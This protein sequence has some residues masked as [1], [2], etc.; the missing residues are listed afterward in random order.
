VQLRNVAVIASVLAAVGISACGSSGKS[1]SVASAPP[2]TTT[3]PPQTTTHPLASTPS[4]SPTTVFE[5]SF[6]ARA[7]A[8]CERAKSII[9]AHG[10]FPYPNFDPLHPELKLL[11]KLGAFLAA[12]QPVGDRVPIE[13]HDLGT[14]RESPTLWTGIVNLAKRYRTI[15]DRQIKAAEASNVSAFVATVNE[16]FATDKQLTQLTSVGGLPPSS[17]CNQVL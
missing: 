6:I 14:P 2:Q 3:A 16:A 17:P 9:A 11:Q 13:L 1:S 7:N 10:Q 8:V 5:A 12:T 15:A 4:P